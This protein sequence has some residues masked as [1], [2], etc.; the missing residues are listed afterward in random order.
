MPAEPANLKSVSRRTILAGAAALPALTAPAVALAAS[1]TV[2]AE[3]VPAELDPIFAA[4][5]AHRQAFLKQIAS[6]LKKSNLMDGTPEHD[7]A[8]DEHADDWV[9]YHNASIDLLDIEPTSIAGVLA[10]LDYVQQ[11]NDGALVSPD[12]P[13]VRSNWQ[14]WPCSG[15]SDDDDLDDTSPM[16]WHLLRAVR[17]ALEQFA[18]VS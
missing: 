6:C 8:D 9:D 13:G 1:G 14:A 16:A 11:L 12:D 17:E 5:D 10:L 3:M 15:I 18:A 2:P 4:I 7:A